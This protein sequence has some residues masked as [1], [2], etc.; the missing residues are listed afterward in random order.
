MFIEENEL[1]YVVC[2]MVVVLAESQCVNTLNAEWEKA[3]HI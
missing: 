2:D 3:L 1:E